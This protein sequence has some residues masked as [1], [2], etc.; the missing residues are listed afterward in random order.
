M[1]LQDG[2]TLQ[3]GKYKIIRFIS[4]GGF[5]C[6]YEA[7][8][9]MLDTRVAIKEFFV[10][11]FCNR[12]ETTCHVTVGTQS[13]K[14]LVDKLRRK[15]ID[16]AKSLW[17]LQHHGIVKVIDVFEENGT[18]YYVMD[19]INGHSLSELVRNHPLPEKQAVDYIRQVCDALKYVHE[20]NRLHLDIKPANIMITAEGKA[21]LIDFGA[22]KQY[23]E[24]NG[25]N[26]STLLGKTPGYAPPEQMGNDVVHFT[27][28]TDIYAIGATLFK[29]LTGITPPTANM[30][31]SGE[32]LPP[33][34]D[35][36]SKST[37]DAILAAMKLNKRLRPQT[38]DEFLKILDEGTTADSEETEIVDSA[39]SEA[40]EPEQIQVN[41]QPEPKQ[42]TVQPADEQKTVQAKPDSSKQRNKK[43]KFVWGIISG[44]LAVTVLIVSSVLI[45]NE[46]GRRKL[47]D[48]V[49]NYYSGEINGHPYVDLGL[50]SGLLWATCNVGAPISIWT[51]GQEQVM[52]ARTPDG[53]AYYYAWGET[54]QKQ[55]YT[56]ENCLTYDKELGDISGDQS[57]D[58][59]KAQWGETWRMPTK[60]E[61]QELID[62]CTWKWGKYRGN[63]G[64]Y[65]TG[66]N[67][68]SIFLPA[69]GG[70]DGSTNDYA[71]VLGRYWSSSP[72]EGSTQRSHILSFNRDDHYVGWDYRNYGYSVR[73][74]SNPVKSGQESVA[75]SE[76]TS[77]HTKT[78]KAASTNSTPTIKTGSQQAEAK[79]TQKQDPKPA[80]QAQKKLEVQQQMT[81]QSDTKPEPKLTGYINGHEYVDLGLTSGLKWATCNVGATIPE[82]HGNY[83]AWGETTTKSEYD[84][85]SI[86]FNKAIEDISGNSY[87]DA[88]RA[89]WGS[90]WRLPTSAEFQVLLRNCTWKWVTRGTS[91][92]YEV[93]GPNGRSIFL[94]AAGY[95]DRSSLY[96]A[97]EKGYYWSSSSKEDCYGNS[98]ILCFHSHHMY[99]DWL[100]CY[101]GCSVRPVSQ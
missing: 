65:V 6:T 73:P 3:G 59:A 78:E 75:H 77:Q 37:K 23:D 58:V 11:D 74:V 60:D 30:L 90:T 94:P 27:P 87:Y 53:L 2:T 25:E 19:Y 54:K 70:R 9:I 61:F 56:Q 8:H 97:G 76:T 32:T 39:A 98:Y 31:I 28:A 29:A 43:R 34:P 55:K 83:Y 22:S 41:Q 68:N 10:K 40:S 50:P 89:N 7:Q 85:N 95:R 36:I 99:L 48:S 92:G 96:D 17:R 46:A 13:K 88:A 44:I 72:Y 4:N 38:V 81:Q 62:Y 49:T 101:E 93:T 80:P 45:Y 82:G 64:Y 5:G 84:A 18:A 21:V 33:L 24:E 100:T 47:E 86:T 91:N 69:A 67:G 12:D 26:T 71:G 15:F 63:E 52:G 79:E 66:P 16:E 57:Y 51:N 20:N 35:E 14:G 1:Q 42:T